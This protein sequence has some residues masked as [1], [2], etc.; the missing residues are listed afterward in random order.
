MHG[1]V[2]ACRNKRHGAA[3]G[4]P[5]WTNSR[6]CELSPDRLGRNHSTGHHFVGPSFAAVM[7]VHMRR[8]AAALVSCFMVAWVAVAVTFAPLPNRP[9]T[10]KLAVIGDNGTGRAAQDRSRRSDGAIPTT[11]SVRSRPDARR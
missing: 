6:S 3:T 11:V 10:I 2:N 9:G 8:L 4:A 1:R 5:A 7:S